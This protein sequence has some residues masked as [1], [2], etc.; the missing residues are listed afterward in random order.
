MRKTQTKVMVSMPL[1]L[2]LLLVIAVVVLHGYS[3]AAQVVGTDN[4]RAA[5]GQNVTI[6]DPFELIAI[7]VIMT[8]TVLAD[9]I[10][11]YHLRHR[12][13]RSPIKPPMY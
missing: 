10:G 6:L 3:A 11:E 9:E 8:E 7:T 2:I 1:R 12:W 5:I 4:P 13:P